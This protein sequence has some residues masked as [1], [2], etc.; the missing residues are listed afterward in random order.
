M[1]QSAGAG[2]QTCAIGIWPCGSY[3]G[4]Y[5]GGLG[6]D[7]PLR[8]EAAHV[9]NRGQRRSEAKDELMRG[10]SGTKDQAL[11]P[12][13]D[14]SGHETLLDKTLDQGQDTYGPGRRKEKGTAA[15]ADH[16]SARSDPDSA[17]R[18]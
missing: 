12:R 18:T 6:W 5:C 15:P 9:S 4:G 16:D 13:Q 10:V 3:C 1:A 2:R 17:H 8:L 14:T 7:S 11:H